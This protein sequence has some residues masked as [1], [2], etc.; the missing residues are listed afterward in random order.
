M[1]GTELTAVDGLE[2]PFRGSLSNTVHEA[3]VHGVGVGVGP[4]S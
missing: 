3:D 4:H 2:V 1:N